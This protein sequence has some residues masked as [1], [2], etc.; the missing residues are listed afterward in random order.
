MAF[1]SVTFLVFLVATA[2][3][4]GCTPQRLR[5]LLLLAASYVFYGHWRI[6][7]LGLIVA[8]TGIDYCAGLVMSATAAPR[9]RRAALAIA[10]CANLTLLGTFK[11]LG[12]FLGLGESL[13]G[14]ALPGVD[15]LLPVGISFY[16]FQSMAYSIDVYRGAVAAERHA[17]YFALYV[18]FFPQLVAG[19]IERPAHLIGQLKR[20]VSFDTER[21]R[22]GAMQMLFGFFQKI[23][24][25]DNI[26]VIVDA[27]YAQPANS[28]PA[29][30]WIA[31]YLF[32]FQIY[33]DFAGYSNIAIG[34]ARIFGIDLMQNF[35]RPYLSA[36]IPEFWRRWHISLSSW[37][38]DY[39][40]IPLGGNRR[41][42][43]ANIAVV[44][45]LSGLWHGAALTFVAW[46]AIH[47]IVM[48][49]GRAWPARR[50]PTA[51]R[52]SPWR[53]W[54]QRLLT[55]HIV[56]FGWV[57]FRA[58]TFGDALTIVARCV[59]DW[60]ASDHDWPIALD[61]TSLWIALAGVALLLA[62][63]IWERDEPSWRRV[64]RA[65]AVVRWSI[66]LALSAAILNLGVPHAV[67]F[68]YFQF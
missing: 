54:R 12:F 33:C 49:L 67:P 60:S 36:S 39:V 65:P 38:R 59:G 46:G 8:S 13:F 2:V 43:A 34:C 5:W 64:L 66:Y 45:L 10:I 3:A 58:A 47:G 4:Y 42:W 35:D 44:F 50:R 28:P 55:F 22:S 23:V 40:Y 57:F 19:P 37:F 18:A 41:H 26:S 9:A 27:V 11:Y 15:I 14:V 63:E 31:T 32:A 62:S 52:E 1:N 21:I 51:Q 6:G 68:L 56:C 25:A 20:R 24:I 17:G 16:T 53:I 7:Y 30:L 48:W 29:A 61:S